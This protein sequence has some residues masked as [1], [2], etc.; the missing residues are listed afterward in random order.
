MTGEHLRHL[1]RQTK[2]ADQIQ[3]LIALAP[4][5]NSF[6]RSVAAQLG[7]VTLQI[8]RDHTL[9]LTGGI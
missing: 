5:Y 9:D 3:R 7:D 4:I 6:S 2:N 1:G 8:V